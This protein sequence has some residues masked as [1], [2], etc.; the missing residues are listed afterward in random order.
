MS[1]SMPVAMSPEELIFTFKQGSEENFKEA[2]SRINDSFGKTDP[3]MTLSLLLTSF[4]FGLALCYRYALD[5]IVGGDFLHCDGDQAFNAI[6]KLIATSSSTNKFDS[7]LVSIH[8]RLNTLETHISCLKDGYNQ[9]RE[10][11]DYVPTNFEPSMWVPT[12][13]VAICG[14]T[15]Y[16]R[17]D[18]MS[19]FCLM[20]KSIYETL[21]LWGLAEGGEGITLTDNSVIFPEG[22]AEGVFTT[23][24]GRTVSTDYLVIECAG[25]GQ[26]TLGRSLLKLMGATIDVG[27]GTL[28]LTST[29]RCGHVFSKPKSKSKGKRGRRMALG[30]DVNAPSLDNT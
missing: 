27:K 6:K 26:I 17:C 22:I 3:K 19:E 21:N 16:A 12:V 7:A 8:A 9:I 15:F 23:F 29:P 10:Y 24:L 14:E 25:T 28:N 11:F 5:A 4:Y 30:I 1:C 18:I 2:W 20:P 13:K